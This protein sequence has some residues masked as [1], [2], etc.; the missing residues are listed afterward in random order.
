MSISFQT[1]AAMRFGYGFRP[2]EP[3]PGDRQAMLEQIRTGPAATPLFPIGGVDERRRLIGETADRLRDIRTAVGADDAKRDQER[4]VFRELDRRYQRDIDARIAQ[5]VFSPSGFYERLAGFWTN[6]FSVSAQKSQPMRLIVPL[7]EAEAIRPNIGAKFP[8][9]L[10]AVMRHPAM[11]IYLDQSQSLGPDSPAGIKRNKGLNENLA[12]ELME[13]HTLGAGSGYTQDDVRSAAMV[14]TG[15]AVDQRGATADFRPGIAEPGSHDVLGVSYGGKRRTEQDYLSMLDD[16][17]LNPKTAQHICRKLAV[18]FIADVPPQDM[19]DAM[20]DCWR[21][22]DGDLS[23]VYAT[24]L[25]HPA[26]W[27]G[28]GAKARQP[29]DFVVAG[30]RALNLEKNPAAGSLA[31]MSDGEPGSMMAGANPAMQGPPPAT[32]ILSGLAPDAVKL[33]QAAIDAGFYVPRGLGLYAL[34]RMGQPT[35]QPPSPAGFPEGFDAWVN[36][37]ELAERLSWARRAIGRYGKQHDPR[38]F[39]K[40]TLADAARDDTIRVVSQAPNRT[41]GLTLVLASPEFNRR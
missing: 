37:S 33:Q 25:D 17:A 38:Q 5:A 16:L 32:G 24:M 23:A 11:L 9:L 14:L 12:R 20:A 22:S 2:G 41:T 29:F 39:L 18:H 26:A 10:R 31:P 27:S 6:H 15:I 3:A 28:E 1:M 13:L 19:V 7:F 34:R 35:W 40:D 36:A 30:L 4:T 8:V 21:N